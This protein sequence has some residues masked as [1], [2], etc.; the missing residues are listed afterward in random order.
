MKFCLHWR[1]RCLC[2]GES[3]FDA[4]RINFNKKNHNIRG[5]PGKYDVLWETSS[6]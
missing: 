2:P 5:V 3:V 6:Y 1:V 4:E